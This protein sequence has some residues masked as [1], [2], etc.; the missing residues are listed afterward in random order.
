MA[1]GVTWT[2][3]ACSCAC[4]SAMVTSRAVNEIE[5]WEEEDPDDVD[6]VPVEAH[7]L[8]R[9]VIRRTEMPAR[10]A[11]DD[12]QQQPDADHHVQG[13][14]SRQ[15]PVERHEQLDLRRERGVLV[16]VPVRAGEE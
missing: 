8:D 2:C 13:V 3:G 5:E 12:P 1:M 11:A 9:A 10:G 7:H 4:S 15:P 14:Q 16:P 6:E